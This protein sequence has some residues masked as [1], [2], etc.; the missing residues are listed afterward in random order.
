MARILVVEDEPAI[1]LLLVKSL[2]LVGHACASAPDG[3]TAR[4]LLREEHF[5]LILLDVMLPGPD[6][7]SLMRHTG[8]TPVIF[9]TAK[10]ALEDRVRGLTLGADDY[11][12]KPFEMEELIAR[13][14]AVLRRASPQRR[15]VHIAGLTVDLEGRTVSRGGCFI[16]CTPQEFTLFEA[17]LVNRN[18]ALSRS[19][20]LEI[21]WG[22][23]FEGDSRTVDV[24][25]QRLRK[26]LSL[27][28]HIKTV[29]KLGYRLET[30]P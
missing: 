28:E 3:E 29:Y 11:I 30:A 16:E 25:I 5:E 27:E 20:L 22:Y 10:T 8:G 24:H 15:V 14:D 13:V 26:K 12:T 6:G 17:L 19:K 1:R 9:L 4:E 21:A 2:K 23:D 18:I 7:F